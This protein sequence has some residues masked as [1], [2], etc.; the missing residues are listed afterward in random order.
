MYK[1]M[2]VARYVINYS[3]EIGRPVSNLKLQK[4]LYFIQSDFLAN[5]GL[6]CFYEEIEAWDFG[7]VVPDVYYTYKK[8]GSSII[9]KIDNYIDFSNGSWNA[10]KFNF[11]KNNISSETDRIRIEKMIELC[12]KYTAAQLVE[13]TH[14]QL[15]WKKARQSLYNKVI[16]KESI[17][18]YFTEG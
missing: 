9:T 11:T 4:I 7:P 8:Y 13:I 18:R 1:V 15:P 16:S 12:S 3:Y 10:N 2:D 5:T 14:N 17:T 6:P